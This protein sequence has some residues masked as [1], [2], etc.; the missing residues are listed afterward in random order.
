MFKSWRKATA[1]S[2]AGRIGRRFHRVLSR[3]ALPAV[4]IAALVATPLQI[5]GDPGAVQAQD[6]TIAVS[7]RD[8]VYY[9]HEDDNDGVNVVSWR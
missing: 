6:E 5:L 4:L 2:T 9:V 7:F 3:V 8:M 1:G